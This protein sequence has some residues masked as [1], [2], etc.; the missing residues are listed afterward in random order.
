MIVIILFLIFFLVIIGFVVGPLF[1][2]SQYSIDITYSVAGKMI[3]KDQLLNIGISEFDTTKFIRPY[4]SSSVDIFGIRKLY[5]SK[6]GGFE[7]YM[8]MLNPQAD[9]HLYNYDKMEKNSDQSYNSCFNL[10]SSRMCFYLYLQ[11]RS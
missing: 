8:N 6:L 3:K 9:P 10:N 4:G 5:D 1:T 7:W 11:D 2:S